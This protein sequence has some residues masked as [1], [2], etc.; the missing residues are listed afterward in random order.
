MTEWVRGRIV[1]LSAKAATAWR[2]STRG[3][4]EGP[5]APF[6]HHSYFVVFQR[7]LKGP[8]Q[9]DE[10]AVPIAGRKLRDELIAGDAPFAVYARENKLGAPIT[11]EF[12]AGGYRARG[13]EEGIVYAPNVQPTDIKHMAWK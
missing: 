10:T 11:A 4:P 9:L 8:T 12:T 6:G 13:Y 7:T 1:N 2:S 5:G 3:V